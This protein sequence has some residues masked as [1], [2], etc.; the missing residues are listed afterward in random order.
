MLQMTWGMFMNAVLLRLLHA[1]IL[2]KI[3][4]KC[5]KGRQNSRD[6]VVVSCW[7]QW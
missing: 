1:Y 4:R 7:T 5:H 3:I 6:E 2:M